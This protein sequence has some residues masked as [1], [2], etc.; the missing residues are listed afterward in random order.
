MN[1]RDHESYTGYIAYGNSKGEPRRSRHKN[2]SKIVVSNLE[3]T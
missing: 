1:T 3:G 2:N